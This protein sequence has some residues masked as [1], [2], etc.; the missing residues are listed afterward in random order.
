MRLKPLV[1][2][3]L[4]FIPGSHLFLPEQKAGG[5][6]NSAAYCYGVW[7]IHLTML[8]ENGLRTIP[9]SLAELGPGESLGVGLSAMLSGVNHYYALD[10]LKHADTAL[11]LKIFDELVEM[12]TRR[13][14][15]PGNG[16]P[17][18]GK[19]LDANLFPSHI[20]TDDVL[21]NT[22]EETR[23][24]NIR[25]LIASRGED[26]SVTGMS[27]KY[28]APWL[29]ADIIQ[30][31]SIDAIISHSVLEHVVD[32]EDAYVVMHKWLKPGGGMSHYIDIRA[33]GVDKIE[34]GHWKFSE[35][36]W[37]AILGK[38]PYLINRLPYSAHRQF[39][40]DLGFDIVCELKQ[41]ITNGIQRHQLAKR[42]RH[43]SDDDMTCI[44]A[45]LQAKKLGWVSNTISHF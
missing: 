23:V 6:G 38:R 4:T 24:A 40:S 34:N 36:L 11:N 42:W 5:G 22:L 33:H 30:K 9:D 15:K 32:I 19:Y 13:A 8:W 25:K 16:W 7:L 14:G 2:G 17:D 39:T 20:L 27:L 18:L 28:I 35:L 12:F 1:R 29:D 41:Y 3:L 21:A 45:L 10:T 26:T 43:L 44:G 31:D 37:K